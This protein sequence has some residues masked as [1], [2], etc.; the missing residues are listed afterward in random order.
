VGRVRTSSPPTR[1]TRRLFARA[2]RRAGCDGDEATLSDRSAPVESVHE[3]VVTRKPHRTHE[4]TNLVYGDGQR[5]S[6]FGDAAAKLY[7][8][9]TAMSG[10]AVNAAT[11]MRRQCSAAVSRP[12]RP[13][14]VADLPLIYELCRSGPPIDDG[15]AKH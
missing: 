10:G 9:R 14:P 8:R 7:V 3:L 4:R 5:R 2:G 1:N 6:Q 13:C 12:T 11:A 15:T